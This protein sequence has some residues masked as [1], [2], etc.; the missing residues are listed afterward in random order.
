M[1]SFHKIY[2]KHFTFDPCGI[3]VLN[4][5]YFCLFH[6]NSET[7][8]LTLRFDKPFSGI[9]SRTKYRSYAS[10]GINMRFPSMWF[11]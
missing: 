3:F 8:D 7:T 1:E 2:D 4:K 6:E 10:V 5:N 9:V 11:V